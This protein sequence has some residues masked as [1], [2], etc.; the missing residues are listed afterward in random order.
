MPRSTSITPDGSRAYVTLRGGHGVSVIDLLAMQEVDVDASVAGL[1]HIANLPAS[2][3]PFWIKVDSKGE[4][5]YVSDEQTGAIYVIDVNPRSSTYNRWI[6]TIT[7]SPAPFGLR[8]LDIS[9]DGHRLYVAAPERF[10]FQSQES[11]RGVGNIL[12]VNVD[13]GDAPATPAASNPQKYRE[14]IKS[15]PVSKEPYGVTATTDPHKILF[16]NRA[17]D[18]NGVGLLQVTGDSPTAFTTSQ[19]YIR[20]DLP[21]PSDYFDV[22]NGQG[23][24]GPTR[25]DLCV[26][27]GLQ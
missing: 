6:R 19:S 10:S 4:F 26:C 14:Q 16:T 17:L 27:H 23:I 2:A 1:Q 3:A 24:A 15:I 18:L 9:S 22:N 25:P 11:N 5:A 21:G 12:V 8:G 13:A 7:V 20:L